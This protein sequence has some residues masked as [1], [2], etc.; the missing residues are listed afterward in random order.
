[1]KR[2]PRKRVVTLDVTPEGLVKIRQP[3]PRDPGDIA[4][5]AEAI[6]RLRK[7]LGE[8]SIDEV[9]AK[10]DR[11]LPPLHGDE[12][13]C[14]DPL[15]V[16]Q[17]LVMVNLAMVNLPPRLNNV[18]R[19]L[20]LGLENQASTTD[21]RRYDAVRL[22]KDNGKGHDDACDL[23]A[24]LLGVSPDATRKSFTNGKRRAAQ[25]RCFNL[26]SVEE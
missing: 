10:L 26:S 22:F 3:P 2:R 4:R 17:V 8:Q 18:L 6:E 1:V 13:I 19:A 11:Q 12:T 14:F 24:E 21:D 20:L 23:A 7:R 25:R 16:L 15:L 5:V 9:L